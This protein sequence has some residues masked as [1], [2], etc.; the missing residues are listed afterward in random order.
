MN[1]LTLDQGIEG[2]NPSSPANSPHPDPLPTPSR[3]TPWL[4]RWLSTS[5]RILFPPPKPGPVDDPD[6]DTRVLLVLAVLSF[7]GPIREMLLWGPQQ[8]CSFVFAG[9][10]FACGS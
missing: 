6:H 3:R 4:S 9:I 8:G 1:P 5:R 7:G 2:S 10:G